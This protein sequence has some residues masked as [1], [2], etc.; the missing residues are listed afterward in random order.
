MNRPSTRL[1]SPPASG[2]LPAREVVS[3][4]FFLSHL[5]LI[6][7][8]TRDLCCRNRLAGAEVDE[9]TA[10]VRLAIL[11]RDYEVLRRFNGTGS[12]RSYLA[13]V[14]SRLL[15]DYRCKQWGRWRPSAEARRRGPV[16]MLLERLMVRDGWSFDQAAE[17]LRTNH[18]VV[19][20]RAELYEL[21]RRLPPVSA[22]V[23]LVPVC[24][25]HDL[26]SADSAP[27]VN[28][29]RGERIVARQRIVHALEQART[30]LTAEE[31]LILSLRFDDGFSISRIARALRLD[32]KKLYRRLK[33]LFA[34]LREQ[35]AANGIGAQDIEDCFADA[36]L[37]QPNGERCA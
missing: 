4:D 5:P 17:I 29:I 26:V 30:T 12:L 7:S 23:Q 9:F 21:Y 32:P 11:E 31:Q 24:A 15:Y 3:E 19:D 10:Q 8:V 6:D 36:D 28:V 1:S 33:T 20:S 25:A 16:A 14:V 37:N 34:R 22:N 27:D 35:L 13:V 18:D 2:T